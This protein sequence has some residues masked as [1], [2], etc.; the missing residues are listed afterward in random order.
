TGAA[1]LVTVAQALHWLDLARF[2]GEVDRVLKPGGLLAVW[3]YDVVRVSPAVDRVLGWFYADRVGRYWPPER[4]SVEMGYS[5]LPF[6]YP[7]LPEETFR[8]TGALDRRQFEGYI[9]TWS[10]VAQC[11]RLEGADPLPEFEAALR[12]VWPD[13]AERRAA[14]WPVF[15]RMGRKPPVA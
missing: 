4:R 13:A 8:M 14:S 15:V 9:G 6:P 3:C 5:D 1:D 2:Y 12:P 7:E 11:R 10:A